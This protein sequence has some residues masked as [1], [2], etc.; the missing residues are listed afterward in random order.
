M[1]NNYENTFTR[2]AIKI[3]TITVLAA[4]VAAF[5]PNIYLYVTQ[6][7]APSFDKFLIAWA[8]V[9]AANGAFWLVEPISYFPIFGVAGNYIGILSGNISSIRLPAAANAQ[10]VLKVDPASKKGEI[11]AVLA[12]C[13][14]VITNI[15]LLTI[16]VSGGTYILS[17]LPAPIQNAIN[18]YVLPSLF[19]ASFAMMAANHVKVACYALPIGIIL[20]LI[21]LPGYI[22]TICAVFGIIA[23]TLILDK[24]GVKDL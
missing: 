18:T 20:R 19:G 2:P 12:I 1:E 23:I 10:D 8:S 4:M 9:L 21:N 14:S 17:M 6:G 15:L 22:S 16:A 3:G 13:G 7:V 11:V 24:K 5:L